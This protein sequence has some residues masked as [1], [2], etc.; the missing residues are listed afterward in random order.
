MHK[1]CAV[2]NVTHIKQAK[3]IRQNLCPYDYLIECN[4]R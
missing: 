1:L 4:W 2:E 3:F